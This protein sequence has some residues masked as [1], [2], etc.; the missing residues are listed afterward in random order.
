MPLDSRLRDSTVNIR[1]WPLPDQTI[2]MAPLGLCPRGVFGTGIR[3]PRWLS[4][5]TK[6]EEYLARAE[7]CEQW[8]KE[9]S[10]EPA[11]REILEICRQW[12]A[13]AKQAE[14]NGW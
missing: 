3:L 9:V 8:A 13:M 4:V 2:R 11:R 12:R 10:Y 1:Y 7:Q 5:P 6:A 14:R